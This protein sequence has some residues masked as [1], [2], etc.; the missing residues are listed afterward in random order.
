MSLYYWLDVQIGHFMHVC[1]FSWVFLHEKAY[2]NRDTG[3]ES[4][5]MTKVKG[6]GT[7]NDQVVDPTDYVSPPQV[8]KSRLSSIFSL[9]SSRGLV[10][11]FMVSIM[12]FRALQ[13]SALL[14]E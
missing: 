1:T 3:I 10:K 11:S 4:T 14:P 12:Y 5:V 13:H 8:S 9:C 2:Q 7:L 6:I